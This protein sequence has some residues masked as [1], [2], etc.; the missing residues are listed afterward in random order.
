MEN[1]GSVMTDK[2]TAIKAFEKANMYDNYTAK[3]LSFAFDVNMGGEMKNNY[4]RQVFLS[5]KFAKAFWGEEKIITEYND[6]FEAK[7]EIA[8]KHCLSQMVL[9]ENILD[10]IRIFLGDKNEY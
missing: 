6:P 10:Y 3:E 7:T 9:E 8:W 4:I 1:G 5:H 2:E